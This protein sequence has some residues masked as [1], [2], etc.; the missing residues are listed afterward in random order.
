MRAC[1]PRRPR[2]AIKLGRERGKKREQRLAWQLTKVTL[3]CKGD[4]A[5]GH[6]AAHESGVAAR[7]RE[8]G[9]VGS[10]ALVKGCGSDHSSTL[11]ATGGA[12]LVEQPLPVL[13]RVVHHQQSL[14][15]VAA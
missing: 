5:V 6:G 9:G 12:R 4:V 15:D 14:T 7:R 11:G 8:S 1:L 10:R 13:V 3:R 2:L